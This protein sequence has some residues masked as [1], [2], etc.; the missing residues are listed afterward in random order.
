MESNN[1][2]KNICRDWANKSCS[3]NPCK[4]IHDPNLC[5][6]FYKTEKC[7]GLCGLSHFVNPDLVNKTGKKIFDT[8]KKN[9]INKHHKKP[10]NTET[11]KPDYSPPEMRIQFEYNKS[12]CELELQSNDVVIVPD[13][14]ADIPNIYDRLLKEIFSTEFDKQELIIPW[15]EGSHL[16]VDDHLDWK[17]SCPT[18]QLI[19]ERIQKYFQMNIKATRFNWMQNL[20]DHKFFHFDGAA[21]KPEIAKIQNCSI[22]VSFGATRDIAFQVASHP[23]CRNVISFPLPNGST[24]LFGKDVNIDWRHGVL[25]IKTDQDYKPIKTDGRISIIAWGWINQLDLKPTNKVFI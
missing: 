4:F 21:L 18:F 6:Q 9:N 12:K 10:T 23:D 13:I 14:F 5:I 24:Y 11:F 2:F 7:N 1:N 25:P 3:H 15:H 16:I 8:N 22:G 20:Q 17:K 19:I